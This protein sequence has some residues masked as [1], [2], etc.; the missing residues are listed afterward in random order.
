MTY[1]I[2]AG[3]SFNVVL[4]HP[5]DSDPSTWDPA[6]AIADMRREFVG[7]DSRYAYYLGIYGF[8]I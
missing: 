8:H 3:K 7:W 2:G 1:T 4:S 5:D 6:T